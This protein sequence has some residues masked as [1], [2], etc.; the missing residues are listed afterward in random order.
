MIRTRPDTGMTH[1]R[2]C[3]L[4]QK[5]LYNVRD[6]AAARDPLLT[7]EEWERELAER[8]YDEDCDPRVELMPVAIDGF[9]G[10]QKRVDA[11]EKGLTEL[12][13]HVKVCA[14]LFTM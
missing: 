7:P 14:P 8:R 3:E 5:I 4:M 9:V 2:I 11:Q 6:P 13:D 12:S 10:L 1:A